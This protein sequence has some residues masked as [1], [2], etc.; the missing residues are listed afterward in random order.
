MRERK[1]LQDFHSRKDPCSWETGW[2]GRGEFLSLGEVTS[3][4]LQRMN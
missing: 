1:G 4:R 2:M 3:G